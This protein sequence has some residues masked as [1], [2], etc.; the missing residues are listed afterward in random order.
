MTK[1]SVLPGQQALIRRSELPEG[2]LAD[3][4]HATYLTWETG[5]RAKVIEYGCRAGVDHFQFAEAADAMGIEDPPNPRSD[6]G[7]LAQSM[8][9]WGDVERV[10]P[11]LA[12]RRTCRRSM[13]WR[14]RVAPE[15]R[16]QFAAKA[17]ETTQEA[18][19]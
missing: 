13:L 12:V 2:A 6:W 1:I 14:W 8:H 4:P 3:N 10:T 11:A 5:A 7:H 17:A 15:A 16:A 9:K 19:A 18:A